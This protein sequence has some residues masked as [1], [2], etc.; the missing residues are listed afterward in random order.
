ML[1]V[2]TAFWNYFVISVVATLVVFLLWA[3][4]RNTFHELGDFLASYALHMGGV[5][6]SAMCEFT[7]A[8][9]FIF[10]SS[11]LILLAAIYLQTGIQKVFIEPPAKRAYLSYFVFAVL[12]AAHGYFTFIEPNFPARTINISAA[13]AIIYL[14]CIWIL[15]NGKKRRANFAPPRRLAYVFTAYCLFLIGVASYYGFFQQAKNASWNSGFYALSIIIHEALFILMT[16]GIF[17]I[18]NRRLHQ[19]V[20]DDAFWR[21]KAESEAR[22]SAERLA[23]VIEGSKLGY[24]DWLIQE[25]VVHR[26]SRWAEILGYTKEEIGSEYQRWKELI[27]P[28]DVDETQRKLDEHLNGGSEY[29]RNEYRMKTKDGSYRWVL[30]QGKVI[31]RDKDGKPL[32]MTATHID[33]TDRKK[34]E[35]A[36]RKSEARFRA[37]FE[38]PL[39]GIAISSPQKGWIEANNHLCRMLEYTREELAELTWDKI[40]HPDDIAE[41]LRYFES[42]MRGE[43]DEYHIDKR[44]ICKSGKI[45]WV[46]LSARVARLPNGE[47]DYLIV[48]MQDITERKKMEQTVAESEKLFRAIFEQAGV[49]VAQIHT[50]SWKII[51]ANEKYSALTGY[52]KEQL[53]SLNIS[54]FTHPDDVTKNR[55]L[56]EAMMRGE[57]RGFTLEKRY[58]RKDGGVVWVNLTVSPMWK[59]GEESSAHIA[60]VEDITARKQTEE[61]LKHANE[62]LNEQLREIQILQESLREQAIRDPLT[63]LY[64]RYFMEEALKQE[65]ARAM[66][67]NYPI[68]IIVLDLDHLKEINGQYG[69]ITGGDAALRALASHIQAMSRSDDVVCRYAG[70]EFLIILHNTSGHTA[71]ERAEE[72]R[73]AIS[74]LRIKFNES[75]FGITFSAGIAAYPAHGSDLENVLIAADYA[76]YQ[77]KN[78]GRNRIKLYGEL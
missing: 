25:G 11:S 32:R 43:I 14:Q 46:S 16:F 74:N 20:Q 65:Y 13:M 26:N 75:E 19:I 45:V 52:E 78:E 3:Q 12:L 61:K 58:I 62:T 18:F 56:I 48:L 15:F 73:Q 59:P 50:Q 4:N 41:N 69:H 30:D 63:G 27:H 57:N 31:K 67:E 29:Y 37:Y 77:A 38:I 6:F 47:I 7:R 44:F 10:L 42:A 64:N 33:I 36:L 2:Q 53:A 68:S 60:V 24:S 40:T 17:L 21:E 9:V 1:E 8:D 55:A 28:E 49:G 51:R 34:A 66:R 72:W 71:R 70:D 54:D 23:A 39:V 22:E 5:F 35:N 76:L